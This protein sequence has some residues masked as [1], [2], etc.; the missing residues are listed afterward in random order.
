M[1][2]YNALILFKDNKFVKSKLDPV[3][4]KP[5]KVVLSAYSEHS[6]NRIIF[7]KEN[8]KLPWKNKKNSVGITS[9]DFT[10]IIEKEIK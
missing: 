7:T 8:H 9:H 10:V 6:K 5:V 3:P 2:L 1:K 4:S